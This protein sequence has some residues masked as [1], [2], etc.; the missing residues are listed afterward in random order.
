MSIYET[1]FTMITICMCLRYVGVEMT[2]AA[3][4]AREAMNAEA[5][6]PR[7]SMPWTVSGYPFYV[8]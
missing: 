1:C 7:E 4:I 6:I 3:L 8:I 5:H 2:F